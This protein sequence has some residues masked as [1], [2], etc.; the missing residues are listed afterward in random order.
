MMSN[1]K[2][3][4]PEWAEFY[5]TLKDAEQQVYA[6]P[7]Y[8]AMLCRK[9]LEEF[10]R[11]MYE[12]DATLE[13][14]YD[15]SLNSLLY[16]DDFKEIVAPMRLQHLNLIRK[17]GNN[18]VHTSIKIKA[19]DSLHVLKLLHGF[20]KW[21]VMVY[22]ET[23]PDIP[24]FDENLVPKLPAH[25]KAKAELR[26]MEAAYL[27]QQEKLQKMQEEL[28]RI[29]SIK[30][31]NIL[32]APA[33]FDPNE[34]QT[35]SMYIDILLKESGWDLNP[36]NVKEYPLHNCMPQGDGNYNGNG[37]ADYVL[38]GND[39]KP[40]AVVEAKKTGRDPRVGQHQA[41]LYA[42]CLEKKFGQR[43]VI[44]YS[45]GFHTW[46]WDDTE[47][48][49]REV[50]GFYSKDEL[51]MLVLRRSMKKKLTEQ[52]IND[53][54]TDRYYQHEAIRTV[55]QALENKN[56]DALLVMA[57]G[58][59]KTRVSASLVDL[60][61]KA[62][63]VKRVL[64]LADRNALIYQA[65]NNLNV[66]LPNLPSVDLTN[67]KED[68]SSRIVFCTYQTMIGLIDNAK[69]DEGR[70]F[71]VGHFDLIIFDEIHRSVYNRYKAIL[72]YFDGI[73]VGLTATPKSETH[74]DTYALFNLQNGNPTYA[75]E[76]GQA[77]SD[78]F[79]V[80]PR[81]ISVP[82][83]FHREGIKY[84]ELSEEDQERYEE[85][86][87]DPL[88]G[89]FPEEIESEALNSWLFNKD[90]VDKVLGHLMENGLKI[91]GGD[92]LGKTIIFAKS[93]KHAAFI[94]ERFDEQYPYLGDFMKVIDYQTEYRYD[95][96]NRFKIKD[97]MPQIAVSVDM[98]DTGIDVP[99]VLNLLFFKPVRSSAKYWQMIGRGTRLCPE[100]FGPEDDKKCFLIFD[101]CE[102]FEFFN[103]KPKGF[104][105]NKTKS[106]SQRLFE[107]RLKLAMLMAAEEDEL[108]K[109][110]SK[111]LYTKLI[112]QTQALEETNFIVRQH[113]ELVKKYKDPAAWNALG[114]LDVKEL[115]DYISALVLESSEHESAKRFDVL[116]YDLQ[117]SLL[118]A[119]TKQVRIIP[120][121]AKTASKLSKKTSI[122]AVAQ[123][124][125]YITQAQQQDFW[126][127]VYLPD[128]EVLRT[129]LRDLIK[130]LDKEE[131][132]IYYTSYEDQV[133]DV[134]EH[135]LIYNS[136]DLDAYKRRM[137]Q[138]LKENSR[139]MVIGKLRSNTPITRQ[140]LEQLEILLFEQ[141]SLGTK[142]DFVVAYGEQP[143]GRFIRS[144][145]GLDANAAKLAFGEILNSQTLNAQQIRFMDMIINFFTVKGIVEPDMLFV[146]PFTDI[147]AGGI[148]KI[149]DYSTSDKIISLIRQVNENAG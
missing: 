33:P 110:Q 134:K 74:H 23:S 64:F 136:N 96:L 85:D 52:R 124:A 42:D 32:T 102:N 51:Q 40:L 27:Q 98:L 28:E 15:N 6:A 5:D 12:H 140:E 93:S 123:K 143:L 45:N 131:K 108:L 144:I 11:W 19:E 105:G 119:D 145:L 148:M 89:E 91:E 100:L 10:V 104:E 62:G 22:S 135:E 82:T 1:F 18:A 2:F 138:F 73:R 58:T 65:K 55:S 56:R 16:A 54:I 49:P 84:N 34:A 99:E 7:A 67:E 21:A 117:L 72:K 88:T 75:Y 38:W 83:K 63:W 101:L 8:T 9:S 70:H 133:L 149:F 76:L 97:R 146:A 92:K 53:D 69:S 125:K 137:E 3:L 61:S 86:F 142:E 118:N 36:S 26:Q 59:G 57:T 121:V 29:S 47:Y 31:Q 111:E 80:P 115:F 35:R 44:F 41:K 25:E 95:I 30:E 114:E 94:Q 147:N 127:E 109:T 37:F 13:L 14:P 113:W 129:E 116:M 130:F 68:E 141:G 122:P 87:S 81:A 71:G 43:P 17:L 128:V 106:L 46:I 24:A 60:L 50:Y 126:Q 112:G 107:L 139:N 66:Y 4:L 132:S 120:K 103:D 78:G 39:G 20:V 48:P 90:T 79:L 77:V